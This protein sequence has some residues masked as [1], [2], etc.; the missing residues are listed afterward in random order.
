MVGSTL[1]TLSVARTRNSC[2]PSPSDVYVTG[3][4]QELN[5][6]ES[7]EHS[8]DEPGSFEEKMKVADV[9]AVVAAGPSLIVVSGARSTVQAWVA[10]LASVLPAASVVRTDRVCPPAERPV[11]SAG[12]VQEVYGALSSE[13]S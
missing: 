13:H 8:N 2:A 5:E 12:E 11:Y 1:P 3:E 4:E 9:R 7:S 10:G 6:P